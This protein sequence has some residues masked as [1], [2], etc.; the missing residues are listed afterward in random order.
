MRFSSG[1]LALTDPPTL[2][3]AFI[4]YLFIQLILDNMR[5]NGYYKQLYRTSQKQNSTAASFVQ[6]IKEANAANA[7]FVTL[8]GRFQCDVFV[9]SC[10]STN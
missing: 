7:E 2:I 9:V 3:I 5:S 1:P 10:V 6:N 4:L 8:C